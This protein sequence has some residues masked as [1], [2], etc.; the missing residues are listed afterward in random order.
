MKTYM[1]ALLWILFMF[2]SASVQ[3]NIFINFDPDM[4][5]S[6]FIDGDG[7]LKAYREWTQVD[8][9]NLSFNAQV[10]KGP[11]CHLTISKK[12]YID[13]VSLHLLKRTSQGLPISFVAEFV[14]GKQSVEVTRE[15]PYSR[16]EAFQWRMKA[17]ETRNHQNQKATEI[18]KLMP[19]EESILKITTWDFDGLN[20][21]VS[22]HE[23]INCFRTNEDIR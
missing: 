2:E 1:I 6:G 22:G 15:H 13:Q 10:K 12:K 5:D 19:S 7:N 11:L 16:I 8:S 21:Q 20:F 4:N 17:I 23:A 18:L 3:A 9:V 14:D